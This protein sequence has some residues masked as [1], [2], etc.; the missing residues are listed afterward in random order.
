MKDL[1]LQVF[2][3][4]AEPDWT[5]LM[6]SGDPVK[7]CL[8]SLRGKVPVSRIVRNAA[9]AGVSVFLCCSENAHE[10]EDAADEILEDERRL[11]V[12]TTAHAGEA[13]EDIADL[14]EVQNRLLAGSGLLAFVD[15]TDRQSLEVCQILRERWE[16]LGQS[17]AK[18][19]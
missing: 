19:R 3:D 16:H 8:L 14:V 13:P 15:T 6:A 9:L 12:L 7:M 10:I 11:N 1:Q 17:I 5:E 4:G 18:S 2:P